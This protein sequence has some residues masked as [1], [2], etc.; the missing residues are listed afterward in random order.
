V[1]AVGTQFN[2]RRLDGNTQVAVIEG[3][4]KVARDEAALADVS[5][6]GEPNDHG[7]GQHHAFIGFLAAG[8]QT[9]V[10]ANKSTINTTADITEAVAW[11]ERRLVFHNER[12]ATVVAEI[13]RY[14]TR[15]F[16]IEGELAQETRLTAT[17]SVDQ[18]ESLIAF[19]QQYSE[20]SVESR[21]DSIVIQAR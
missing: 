9:T 3:R 10:T 17:F 13:N 7:K 19:L 4:V 21:D 8:E 18:P 11:R 15:H 2:V 16:R 14:G 5:E 12:L 1:Q 6:M 20:L